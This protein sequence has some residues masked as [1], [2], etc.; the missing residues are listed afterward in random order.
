MSEPSASNLGGSAAAIERSSN[1]FPVNLFA[2]PGA[3]QG[4]A[5]GAGN[6]AGNPEQVP[7]AQQDEALAP[8]NGHLAVLPNINIAGIR[9]QPN[10]VHEYHVRGKNSI[11]QLDTKLFHSCMYF[12]GVFMTYMAASE[13]DSDAACEKQKVSVCVFR[14]PFC[15]ANMF[16]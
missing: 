6:H 8:G 9:I 15:M 1:I 10:Q 3:D 7:R 16:F 12:H 2:R 5:N 14:F 11:H 4:A 13:H